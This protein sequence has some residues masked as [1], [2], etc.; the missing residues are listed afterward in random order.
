LLN[1]HK[2]APVF[3]PAEFFPVGLNVIRPGGE[4]AVS[5]LDVFV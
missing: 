3:D 2:P 1:P 4:P 5:A